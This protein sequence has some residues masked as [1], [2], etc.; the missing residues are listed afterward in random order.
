MGKEFFKK[1]TDLLQA[2]QKKKQWQKIVISL[3]LVVAMITSGLL[4]HPAITME[5]KAICGQE[6][7][8]HSADCYEK[9][10]V[11]DKE[12]HTASEV[13]EAA[14]KGE[15]IEEHKHSDSCYKEELTC[16]KK[17]HKHSEDC[18]PKETE[19]KEETSQAK[20]TE[21][22]KTT[23][24]PKAEETTEA[25]KEEKKA[26]EAKEETT[27]EKQEEKAE[28]RTLTAK[29]EDYTV[30]VDCPAEAKIPENAELK[31]REI[32]KDK[33][34]DKEEYEAYYKKA[35][36]ALKEKEG[37]ETD[38]ST[39]RFFDISF[40][41][42]GKEI[43]PAAKVEVK[44][45]YYKKVEV[46]DKGEVKS[47]HFGD[48]KTEVLDV[49]TNEENGKM[50]EVTFDATSFS[51]YG[52]VETETL[53]GDVLTAD[54]KTYTVTVTYGADAKIPEGAS[55]KI[56]EF[57][58]RSL[59]Y[60][61]AKALV[62]EKKKAEDEN[63]DESAMGLDALDISIVDK[64][65][66]EIEPEAEVD[67]KIERKSLPEDMDAEA[68]HDT[69]E[70]QHLDESGDTIAVTTVISSEDT[71]KIT[72]TDNTV[73]ADFKISSFSTFTI[74]W[75]Q[76]L[77]VNV[78]TADG[79]SYKITVEYDEEAGIPDGSSLE[80]REVTGSEK[81]K[82]VEETNEL[83]YGVDSEG[84]VSF[85]RFFDIS[86][87]SDGEKI[88]PKKAVKVTII[89]E[90]TDEITGDINIMHFAE[91]GPETLPAEREDDGSIVYEQ[92][93]FS[94]VGFYEAKSIELGAN[95]LASDATELEIGTPSH[96]KTLKDNGD[97][98]Y[99]LTLSVT[100]KGASSSNSNMVDVVVVFDLSGSMQ[101]PTTNVSDTG[102]YGYKR[103]YDG[104]YYVE[105]Y[106]RKGW[107][108]YKAYNGYEGTVYEKDGTE[109]TGPRY[110]SKTKNPT[111]R[112]D[113]AKASINSLA[114]QLLANNG[115]NTNTS[116]ANVTLSLVTFSDTAETVIDRTA[117][118]NTFTSKINR[119]N[120]TGGTN[121]EDALIEANK[122]SAR[123]DST[124]Y[125]IFVS[126]G[127]PTYYVSRFK[128][129]DGT[130]YETDENVTDSYNQA[131]TQLDGNNSNFYG[132]GVFGNVTRMQ[133]LVTVAGS[134]SSTHYQTATDQDSLNEAFANIIKSITNAADFRNVTITD[135]L[136]T[137]TSTALTNVDGTLT[138][139]TV[140][141]TDVSGNE[142]TTESLPAP[143]YDSA[144]GKITWA[145]GSDYHLKDGYKYSV[146]FKVWPSQEAYDLVAALNNGDKPY[147]DL[148]VDE[149]AQVVQNSNG[150]Y[151]L[152]TNTTSGNTV[153]YTRVDTTTEN[154]ETTTT[155]TNGSVDFTNPDPMPLVSAQI[156]VN[157]IWDDSGN[158]SLR[159]ESID[160][161]VYYGSDVNVNSTT[162]TKLTSITLDGTDATTNLDGN[163]VWTG[164]AYIAPGLIVDG[165]TLESGHY[166][167][168]SESNNTN[169]ELTVSAVKP[170]LVDSATDITKEGSTYVLNATNK[171]LVQD[172]LIEKVDASTKE[173]L[174]G[175]EF[176]LTY[177]NASGAD[178]TA[179]ATGIIDGKIIIGQ[180]GTATITGLNVGIYTLTEIKAP[181]GYVI[182]TSGTTIVVSSSG[183]TVGG[184]SALKNDD[185]K[186]VVT[187][188][189]TAGKILPN[190]GGSGTLPYTLCGLM[191]MSAA[192][193]MYGFIMRRRGRRLN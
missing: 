81:E 99:D 64:D 50:D 133:S 106:Y 157:K 25:S 57:D 35:Q 77:V 60:A 15:T 51:V 75:T 39:V 66:K 101:Y 192:A 47:V 42:D 46:S 49:K 159:P 170:M 17:E 13:E 112:L 117:T 88:E 180:D 90:G 63:F 28:A 122:I 43:E 160:L 86:I 89:A 168:V 94:V 30:Q 183:V 19:A 7:H 69:M 103:T 24:A 132:V 156:T 100:G 149:K 8:T 121:W 23:E 143:S 182:Q 96:S 70:V 129:P 32:V 166:Y 29:G 120:A 104:N 187:V 127:N 164:T 153:T 53:T 61:D 98:T 76:E 135:N 62:V 150:G 136:T 126:D 55:L 125:V 158:T 44:I 151:S 71:G 131:V 68:L 138:G 2:K 73:T 134:D 189:N 91:D 27:E 193:M 146:T 113:V 144:T 41:V 110:T 184:K 167:T 152:N 9:K 78:L 31:V 36:D 128:N 83:L 72:T 33:K 40:M 79:T 137:L 102:M 80:A 67:V 48:D 87:I 82:Y 20:S 161:D 65:G 123:K 188:E 140:K 141:V 4:I 52:V 181:D 56:T 12:E 148:T 178:E 155:D 190:T 107:T 95:L 14:A 93:S 179:T 191:L 21:E 22:T 162:G 171:L 124:K 85:S 130:G 58:E 45:T 116:T 54:G 165:T 154:G 186:Y 16:D 34:S 37:Q 114:T 5:R 18:Y 173:K 105:L 119:T 111:L 84:S 172:L 109:Y 59:D 108:W 115:T 139:A 1:T 176:T 174:S 175:A 145:L 185:G 169:Y 97:G 38:I 147:N 26:D 118:L 74:T 11:C 92:S 3:S 177:K 163:T 10:L 142:V 6:E